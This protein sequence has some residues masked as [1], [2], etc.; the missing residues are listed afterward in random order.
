LNGASSSKDMA[1]GAAW[2]KRYLKNIFYGGAS[3]ELTITVASNW[4]ISLLL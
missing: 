1:I 3:M 2:S 4:H